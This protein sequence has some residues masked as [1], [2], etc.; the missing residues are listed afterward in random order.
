M[1]E[2]VRKKRVRVVLCLPVSRRCTRFLVRCGTW[3]SC[4]CAGRSTSCAPEGASIACLWTSLGGEE[5][6]LGGTACGG[7]KGPALLPPTLYDL[8]APG[9]SSV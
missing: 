4:P 8:L 2:F 7:P 6:L 3:R 9:L 5:G 1:E